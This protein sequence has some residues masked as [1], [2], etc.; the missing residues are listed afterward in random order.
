LDIVC[1]LV[2]VDQHV[3]DLADDRAAILVILEKPVYDALK[4]GE[5]DA[6]VGEEGGLIG[7]IGTSDALHKWIG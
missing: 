7:A 3:T 6:V 5:I 2:L 1:V 4:M